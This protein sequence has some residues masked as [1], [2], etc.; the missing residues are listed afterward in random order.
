MYL[1]VSGV[2]VSIWRLGTYLNM[3][4]HICT[5][6]VYLRA[7]GVSARIWRICAYLTYLC[8]PGVCPRSWAFCAYLNLFGVSARTCTRVS[9]QKVRNL[10]NKRRQMQHMVRTNNASQDINDWT[11]DPK[12]SKGG[13]QH[14]VQLV[15]NPS[16]K[17]CL[18]LRYEKDA[19]S[20]VQVS[21]GPIENHLNQ[22]PSTNASMTKI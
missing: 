14:R 1:Q 8:V 4:A 3:S 18:K 10:T 2:Y 15:T 17:T 19:Q 21:A 6:L 11:Y 5:Y 7:S 20:D 9:L 22:Q 12:M 13:Y 16:T